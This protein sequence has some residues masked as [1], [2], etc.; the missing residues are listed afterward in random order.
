LV[1][2]ADG[3]SLGTRHLRRPNAK[4]GDMS[5]W[6]LLYWAAVLLAT[7]AWTVLAT[8]HLANRDGHG[9]LEGDQAR[10]PQQVE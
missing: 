8:R 3:V 10:Q 6:L 5:D 2:V 9:R 7:I 4:D 1:G